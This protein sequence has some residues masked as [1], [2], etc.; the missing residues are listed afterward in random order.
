MKFKKWELTKISYRSTRD[1]L[2]KGVVVNVNEEFKTD[3]G[4]N[5]KDTREVVITK[6][7]IVMGWNFQINKSESVSTFAFFYQA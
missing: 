5:N 1:Y 3:M 7:E 4:I 6:G 2:F